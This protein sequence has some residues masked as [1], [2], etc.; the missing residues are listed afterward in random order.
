VT[1]DVRYADDHDWFELF[2]SGP[3]DAGQILA[4]LRQVTSHPK[5]NGGKSRL[6]RLAANI[7]LS[8]LTLESLEAELQP[9]LRENAAAFAN[10]RPVAVVANDDT[11]RVLVEFYRQVP[12]IREM[13]NAH[14]FTSEAK[15][16]EFLETEEA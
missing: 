2:Y 6:V 5:W 14:P 11:Q 12:A 16:I 1:V 8:A 9:W 3:V 7:D 10:K 4:S 15:A 13:L